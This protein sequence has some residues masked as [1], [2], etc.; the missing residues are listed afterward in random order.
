M[1]RHARRR[2]KID[3]LK[4][5]NQSGPLPTIPTFKNARRLF[6]GARKKG[7]AIRC[8]GVTKKGRRCHRKTRYGI[9]CYQHEGKKVNRPK[10]GSWGKAL[11]QFHKWRR[12]HRKF[13]MK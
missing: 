3:L 5:V 12:T 11:T 13:S 6:G 9:G 4:T 10:I 2:D 1:T 7:Y 8:V